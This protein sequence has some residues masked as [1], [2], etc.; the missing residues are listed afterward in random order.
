LNVLSCVLGGN[1]ATT[2]GDGTCYCGTAVGSN[3][4]TAGLPNGPCLTQEQD[5]T[6]TTTPATVNSRFTA[7]AYPA[8]MANTILSCAASN[9][10]SQCF[11]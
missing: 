4:N 5:G 1:C 11:P 6:D 10:C 8:G 3:C 7:I 2:L 9:S